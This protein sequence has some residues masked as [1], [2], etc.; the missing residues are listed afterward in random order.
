MNGGLK[1]SILEIHTEVIWS[2]SSGRTLHPCYALLA[3]TNLDFQKAQFWFLFY[4]FFFPLSII[5]TLSSEYLFRAW[6]CGCVCVGMSIVQD[7][8]VSPVI[9]WILHT[10][11]EQE[12]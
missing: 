4:W 1:A 11:H 12:T 5:L 3:A 6:V 7:L 2:W 8:D 9:S 10:H